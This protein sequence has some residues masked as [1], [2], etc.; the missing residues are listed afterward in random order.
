MK[1]PLGKV[2]VETRHLS[3]LLS[4]DSQVE[5]GP[6]LRM[7]ERITQRTSRRKTHITDQRKNA[8]EKS[9]FLIYFIRDENQQA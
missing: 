3:Y 5:K 6:R 7:Q 1:D 9:L 8:K 4:S 2:A